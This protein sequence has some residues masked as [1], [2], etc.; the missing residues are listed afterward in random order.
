MLLDLPLYYVFQYF[1]ITIYFFSLVFACVLYTPCL[2]E[3]WR[4]QCSQSMV[5]ACI[6]VWKLD[7]TLVSRAM[8]FIYLLENQQFV[9]VDYQ[10]RYREMPGSFCGYIHSWWWSVLS[11]W[12]QVSWNRPLS[13][14]QAVYKISPLCV[15][16]L[17][18]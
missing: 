6:V 17:F 9:L 10:P 13:K 18:C 8:C 16:W 2:T 4:G 1:V 15:G 14:I 12:Y 11:S 7:V 3:Q 5:E